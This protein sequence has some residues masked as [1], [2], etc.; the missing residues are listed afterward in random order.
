MTD[1]QTTRIRPAE[2]ADV[3]Q[4]GELFTWVF[5]KNAK[6]V[7]EDVDAYLSRLL[8]THP[9]YSPENGSMVSVDNA[10]SVKSALV[11]LPMSY[12][13]DEEPV[14][15]RLACAFMAAEDASPRS[16]AALI[17]QLRPRGNQISFSDSAAPV[18]ISHLKAIGGVE[19]HAQGLRW[20]KVFKPLP[21]AI[22]FVRRKLANRISSLVGI[23]KLAETTLSLGAKSTSDHSVFEATP[24]LYAEYANRYLS[25]N[26][27]APVYSAEVLEW[28]VDASSGDDGRGRLTLAQVLDEHGDIVG[29][30]SFV[31]G[32][33][34]EAQFLDFLAEDGKADSVLDAAF[35]ALE[36][37][38]FAFA[39]AQ[40]RP[41]MIS[42]LSTHKDIWYRHV[43]GVAAT[44]R[45]AN[46]KQA[47]TNG[48]A[49]IGGI[50]G[51]SWSRLVR[52]FY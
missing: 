24:A 52:D 18:S 30:F 36:K 22:G 42:S 5:R 9:N 31:G 38:G 16:I 37:S 19:L 14:T 17:F 3:S 6:P 13:I 25:K 41:E 4:I 1:D 10:G 47:M 39:S 34:G 8:F 49:Y 40:L 29:V 50:A 15:A 43:T 23:G 51:E 45:S 44:S 32:Y 11:I 21:S 33:G 48:Q 27:V 7:R 46:F 12:R 26:I 28:T 35:A 20:Y 2:P